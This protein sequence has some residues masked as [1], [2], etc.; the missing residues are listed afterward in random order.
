MD[1][2]FKNIFAFTKASCAVAGNFDKTFLVHSCKTS[3]FP[4]ARFQCTP[5]PARYIYIDIDQMV[6]PF[7]RRSLDLDIFDI[8]FGNPFECEII[9]LAY[10]CRPND[11]GSRG[12]K[13]R[14]EK[15]PPTISF[16][17]Q[18]DFK[19]GATAG[20]NWS[21]GRGR[22]VLDITEGMC[23]FRFCLFSHCCRDSVYEALFM[24]EAS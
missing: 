3:I 13:C 10:F 22:F 4:G 19:R 8:M 21:L 18:A 20:K 11:S 7:R 9:P 24:L 1:H 12:F 23:N 14:M 17:C 5:W 2:D 16:N 15:Y 6:T